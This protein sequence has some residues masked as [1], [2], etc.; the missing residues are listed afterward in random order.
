MRIHCS[1]IILVFLSVFPNY[2][3]SQVNCTTV[4]DP[5]VLSLVSVEPETGATELKWDLSPSAGIAAYVLYTYN[6]DAG[7]SFDTIWNPAA[8]SYIYSTPATMYFSVSYVVAALRMPNCISPLSNHLNTIFA[9][10]D[11]DTCNRRISLSWNSYLSEPKKV[12]GYTILAS[13]NGNSFSEIAGMDK[14]K[15]IFMIED[16]ITD[17]EY[18]FVV[19]AELEGGTNSKSNKTCL[20]TSMQ[21]PPDWINADYATVKDAG[22]SLSFTIDPNSEISNFRLERKAISNQQKQTPG[23]LKWNRSCWAYQ[24]D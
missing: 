10:A 2:V 20:S 4:P 17:A 24:T 13:I 5:P 9:E 16:F 7:I 12:T 14:D 3:Q 23:S 21:R 19:I 15:L 6:N 8:T 18:C 1:Y 11:I 22:I